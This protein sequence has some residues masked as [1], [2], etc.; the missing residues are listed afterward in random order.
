M[1][2]LQTLVA[3]LSHYYLIPLVISIRFQRS[4]RG[5]GTSDAGMRNYI[6]NSVRSGGQ[7]QQPVQRQP[8]LPPF[9]AGGTFGAGQLARRHRL[10]RHEQ[11]QGRDPSA[12]VLSN[13]QGEY[14]G[15]WI[16]FQFVCV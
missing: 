2:P 5:Q 15:V 4:I 14:G 3:T 1:S 13:S 9:P 16:I 10:V 8:H 11:L 7:R 6:P 12:Y